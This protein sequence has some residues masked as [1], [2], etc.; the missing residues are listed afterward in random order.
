[1]KKF[2]LLLIIT[3]ALGIFVASAQKVEKVEKIVIPSTGES[4]MVEP[5]LL[6]ETKESSDLILSKSFTG[7]S[8]ESTKTFDVETSASLL[9]IN[10]SGSTRSGKISIKFVMPDGK[11]LKTIEIDPAS[12]VRWTKKFDLTDKSKNYT[13]K[14]KL[15]ITTNK[16][17]GTYRLYIHSR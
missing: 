14:W 7:E 16:A 5:F 15:I 10:L 17:E 9:D 13:G 12:D 3:T 1:M 8:I 4:A 11:D 6:Q 2:I